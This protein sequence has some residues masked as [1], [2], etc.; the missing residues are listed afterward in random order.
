MV[1]GVLLAGTGIAQAA[2]PDVGSRYEFR[3]PVFRG[4]IFCDTLD[5]VQAIASAEQPDRTY[6]NY[7]MTTNAIGEPICMAIAPTALVLAV[8]PIGVMTKNGKDY[9]A[10][11]VETEIDGT[12]I[13]ALYLEHQPG[14]LV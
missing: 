11:A 2:P 13:F 7:Y 9:A 1:A 12:V 4:T 3:D 14:I 10:W 8:T 5:A 6:A